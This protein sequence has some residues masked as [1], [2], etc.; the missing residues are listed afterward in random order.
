[1]NIYRPVSACKDILTNTTN[2]TNTKLSPKLTL[3]KEELNL[4]RLLNHA[5]GPPTTSTTSTANGHGHADGHGHGNGNGKDMEVLVS[6]LN[7][8]EFHRMVL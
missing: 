3:N 7:Q 2:T 1:L 5:L 4:V 6:E 8:N